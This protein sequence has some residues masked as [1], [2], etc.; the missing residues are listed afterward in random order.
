MRIP[1]ECHF[2]MNLKLTHDSG[3]T[4]QTFQK[5]IFQIGRFKRKKLIKVQQENAHAKGKKA[6]FLNDGLEMQSGD[7]DMTTQEGNE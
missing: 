3:I 4:R 2:F 1:I 7:D 5:A 6:L